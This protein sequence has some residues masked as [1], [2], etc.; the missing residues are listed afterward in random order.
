MIIRKQAWNG[1]GFLDVGLGACLA[2]DMGLGKTIQVIALFLLMKQD[3]GLKQGKQ[4]KE[5][6][7]LLVGPASLL[8]NWK[9][10]IASFCSQ[11][12]FTHCASYS[13]Q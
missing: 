13:G 7:S 11:Y 2:D 9:A 8:G 10:E 5:A 6:P 4:Q 3:K 1:S 12:P